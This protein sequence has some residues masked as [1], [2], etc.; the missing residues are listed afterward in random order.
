MSRSVRVGIF[1]S[2][3]F[4]AALPFA[5]A[6]SDGSATQPANIVV[7]VQ[8]HAAIKR[9]NWTGFAPLTFGANL[10]AGDLLH[11]DQFSVAKVV[12]ADLKLHDLGA[13]MM[14][15]P[16]TSSQELLRRPD[17]SLLRPTRGVPADGLF[18]VIV[19]P[20][21]TKILSEHPL[22]RWTEVKDAFTYHVM[23]RGPELIW[24]ANVPFKTEIQYPDNAQK[25]EAGQNYKLIVTVD[26]EK[27]S[28]MESGPGHGFSV[29]P[30]KERKIVLEEQKQLEHL[31]LEEGPTQYLIAHLFAA[32]GLNAEAIQRLE[33]VSKKFQGPATERLLGD[34][35]MV[36]ELPRQAET[37]YLKSLEL[38][39]REQD[40]EGQ[41]QCRLALAA[42]YGKVF[43]NN[44]AAGEHLEAAIAI[45]G[46]LGDDATI[47]RARKRLSELK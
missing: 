2:L 18:P 46:K 19:S 25:L 20:R 27:T 40:D 8:G 7:L 36:V 10:E 22:L 17:G 9:K 39:Q 6:Q 23:V 31:G 26:E 29:L 11:L 1:L 13:G 32:H 34:L 38:S 15:T 42:I 28:E 33:A 14:G 12:C 41:L 16:C 30:S 24:T 45:A 4:L 21:F 47:S 3:M 37:H 43:G 35:Y 5:T 44:R